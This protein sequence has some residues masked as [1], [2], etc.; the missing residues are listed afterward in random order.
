MR[1]GNAA[2]DD[3][4]DQKGMIDYAWDHAVI[5]DRL[6]DEIKSKCNFSAAHPSKACEKVLN[7]YYDV[8]YIID[9]YS[10]YTPTCVNANSSRA[11]QLPVTHAN[12]NFFSKFNKWHKRPR[13]YDPCVS[14]YTADYLNRPDVQKAL[15]A[16]VTNIPYPW[17]HC[18]LN[19]T[20][21]NDSPPS[22]L[23]VIRKLIAGGLRIWVYSGDTDGRLPVTATRYTLRKLGLNILQDWKPW[24]NYKQVGGWTVVYNGLV[25]VTIRGAGHE[26][27]VFAPKQALLLIEHFLIDR[28][29]P[30]KPF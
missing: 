14:D 25:F 9:M 30:S 15:H 23:P 21:W 3:E 28:N 19:I 11:R 22:I 20:T 2:L 29:L 12:P 26:V 16:N 7:E 1:I 24:Y 17:T 18:S 6:Y 4:T 27:P 8:Y 10:L 13:G 5:S